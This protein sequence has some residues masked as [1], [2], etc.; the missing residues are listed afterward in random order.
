MS[1]RRLERVW[2][3]FALEAVLVA[4]DGW[5]NKGV[6]NTGS[7]GPNLTTGRE[8]EAKGVGRDVKAFILSVSRAKAA[9]C[10]GE[11]TVGYD[12]SAD[13]PTRQFL[14]STICAFT[15]GDLSDR[16]EL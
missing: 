15:V 5:H 1:R 13:N 12:I 14:H 6:F 10:S 4:E 3:Y 8:V 16:L 9:S 11:S 7:N 2:T